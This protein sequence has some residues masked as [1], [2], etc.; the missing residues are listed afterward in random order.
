MVTICEPNPLTALLP[1]NVAAEKVQVAAV[2]GAT[3]REAA[4]G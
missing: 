1:L 3:G 2:S 4:G